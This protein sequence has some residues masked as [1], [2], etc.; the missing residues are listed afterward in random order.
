MK[1]SSVVTLLT[2]MPPRDYAEKKRRPKPPAPEAAKVR[3]WARE[4]G[5]DVPQRGK[6]RAEIWAAWRMAHPVENASP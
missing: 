1:A 4:H 3:A 2:L 5:M 6:L